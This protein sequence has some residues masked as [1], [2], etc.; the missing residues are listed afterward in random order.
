MLAKYR[1]YSYLIV[2]LALAFWQGLVLPWVMFFTW[3]L[4]MA[5][6]EQPTH[7]WRSSIFRKW[8]WDQYFWD[9]TISWQKVTTWMG[10]KIPWDDSFHLS[11]SASILLICFVPLAH[12]DM[13]WYHCLA[14]G[15]VTTESFNAFYNYILDTEH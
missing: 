15:W 2:T 6:W 12:G 9:A 8:G 1:T 5:V 7:H 13:R 11:K 4:L 14:L 3:G 10:R